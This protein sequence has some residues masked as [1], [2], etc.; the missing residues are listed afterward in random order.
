MDF[1]LS[2]AAPL[3]A[4]LNSRVR[5]VPETSFSMDDVNLAKQ[6]YPSATKFATTGSMPLQASTPPVRDSGM[7]D[8]DLGSLSLDLDSSNAKEPSDGPPTESGDPFGTKLA[9]AEEFVSIGDK[10][11]ARALIEE[12]VAESSGAIRAKAE[13]ALTNLS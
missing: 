10:D 2:D 1:D 5:V 12:V 3:S 13:R 6:D 7:M 9:L 11:G 8:F 4:T